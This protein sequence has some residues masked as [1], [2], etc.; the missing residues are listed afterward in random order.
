MAV[1]PVTLGP[2]L[3][4][5]M[6]VGVTHLLLEGTAADFDAA[7]TPRETAN[8]VRR[9]SAERSPAPAFSTPSSLGG[10]DPSGAYGAVA[11][12]GIPDTI[13]QQPLRKDLSRVAGSGTSFAGSGFAASGE[14]A[15]NPAVW[16]DFWR[17]WFAKVAPAAVLWTYHE[18]G[19]DVTGVGRSVE[20]S[21][22]FK[23]LLG[24]LAL[25][26]GSSVFWPTAMPASAQ[27]QTLVAHPEVF[28]AGLRLLSP[29]VVVVLGEKALEETGYSG[30]PGVFGQTMAEGALLVLLPGIEELL[31]GESQRASAVSILRALF[32]TITFR[33]NFPGGGV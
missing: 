22:F 8:P 7:F 3:R 21:E 15:A 32:S 10:G 18:L 27:E 30:S 26:R 11:A 23:K 5:W 29:Q 19:A 13:P 9:S 24:A 12:R 25:P 20:R 28:A 17:A 16:P 33:K 4:A 2:C 31:R 1:A 14:F 6:N